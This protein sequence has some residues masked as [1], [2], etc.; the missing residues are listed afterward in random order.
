M[1]FKVNLC[2]CGSELPVLY[3]KWIG[4]SEDNINDSSKYEIVCARCFGYDV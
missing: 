1:K 3:F 4:K 2:D